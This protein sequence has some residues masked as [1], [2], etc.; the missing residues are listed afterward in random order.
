MAGGLQN[1]QGII[2]Q[3]IYPRTHM[4]DGPSENKFTGKGHFF[5]QNYSI[6]AREFLLFSNH[7][8]PG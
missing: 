1:E 5:A 4:Y 2:L 8:R 7:L 3:E 6:C